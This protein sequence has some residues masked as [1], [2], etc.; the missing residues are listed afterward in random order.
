MLFSYKSVSYL[1]FPLAT[2]AFMSSVGAQSITPDATL[3]NESSV[4][5]TNVDVGK[6]IPSDRIDGGATRG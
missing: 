3:G 2:L 5:N 6:G 1:T 4:V